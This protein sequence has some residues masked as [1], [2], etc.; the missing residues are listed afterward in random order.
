MS[1]VQWGYAPAQPPPAPPKSR[2]GW[3]IG[4]GIALLVSCLIC[5]GIGIGCNACWSMGKKEVARQMTVA[6]R[7]AMTG[8]SRQAEY[9][10][11]LQRFEAL[12]DADDVNI[13]AFSVLQNRFTDVRADGQIT[14]DEVDHI[15]A[16][17]TDI[18]AGNGTIDVN[19]YPNAR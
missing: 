2:R 9:E 15:M 7:G 14:H 13:L 17:I 10:P 3:L 4:G 5:A 12:A 19:R 1:E 18:N 11:A 8:H 6:I 16:L